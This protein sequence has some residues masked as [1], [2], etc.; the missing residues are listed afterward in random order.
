M[1]LQA[2]V[3]GP[4]RNAV[5][6]ILNP[7]DTDFSCRFSRDTNSIWNDPDGENDM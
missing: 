3:C 1:E 5:D 6:E 2:Q 4:P 7:K